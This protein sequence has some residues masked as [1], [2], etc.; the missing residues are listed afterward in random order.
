MES[1]AQQVPHPQIT[2]HFRRINNLLCPFA[3]QSQG[4]G[5]LGQVEA[6]TFDSISIIASAT[7]GVVFLDAL[8]SWFVIGVAALLGLNIGSFLNVVIY[9]LPRDMSLSRPGSRCPNCET[10]IAFYDNIPVLSWLILLGRSRCCRAPISPRYPIVE[11]IG[12]LI[13]GVLAVARLE[14]YRHELLV[15]EASFFFIVYLALALGLVAAAAIDFEHMILPDSI[16]LGGTALGLLS[17]SFR[18][19]VDPPMA[20][21]GA[22]AGYVGIWFPFIWLHEK[23]RGF[24]GM[25]LGDAKLMMLAGAWFGPFGVLITLFS[26]ALQGTVFATVALLTQGKIEEPRAVKEQRDELIAMIAAATGEE[27]ER[28]QQELADDPLGKAPE[29]SEG[30]PRIAFGPFLALALIELLIFYD[31]IM[32]WLNVYLIF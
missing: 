21:V 7:K 19:E 20:A 14:P 9:R 22:L 25:G 11:L 12:G 23:L 5:S 3:G 6:R 30:G 31:P 4:R 8:P 13:G 24:P 1:L 10:P 17:A 26:G 16:T 2:G 29:D 15:G 32:A 27:K 28:L 18:P